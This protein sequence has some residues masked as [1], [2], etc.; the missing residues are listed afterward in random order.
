V[1]V[2]AWGDSGGQPLLVLMQAP[3]PSAEASGPATLA[4]VRDYLLSLPGLPQETVAQLRRIDH[5]EATLPLPVPRGQA[6]WREVRVGSTPGLLLSDVAGHGSGV[7]WQH[8]GR[9]YGVLGQLPPQQLL[10]VAASLP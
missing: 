6:T 10:R 1:I 7:V 3:S 2:L 8:D 4:Q 5:W 9:V